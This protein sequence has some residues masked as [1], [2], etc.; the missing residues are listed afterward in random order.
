MFCLPRKKNHTHNRLAQDVILN[1]KSVLAQ[2][3]HG[4]KLVFPDILSI[5]KILLEELHHNP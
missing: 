3:K 2:V 5:Y 1:A 4:V